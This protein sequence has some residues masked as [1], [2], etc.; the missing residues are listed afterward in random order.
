M[1]P[2]RRGPVEMP[3]AARTSRSLTD[4]DRRLASLLAR[5]L[6]ADYGQ[7]PD[8]QRAHASRLMSRVALR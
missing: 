2:R 6:V 7:F 4:L 5:A 1:T 3:G 8:V